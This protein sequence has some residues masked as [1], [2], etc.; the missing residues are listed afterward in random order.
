M[1][2]KETAKE[3]HEISKSKGFYDNKKNIGEMLM[4][5][6]SELSEALEADRKEEHFNN[7]HWGGDRANIKD[8]IDGKV[9]SEIDSVLESQ[10]N[11]FEDFVKNKFEDEIADSIIRLL[12]IS[13]YM[14]IDIEWHIRAKMEYNKSRERLHGKKY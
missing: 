4:L 12:D 13:E 7:I 11:T 9:L 6:V 8:I 14:N 2:I 3:I 10:K 5:V 1:N